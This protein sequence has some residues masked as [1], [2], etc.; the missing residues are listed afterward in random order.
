[1]PEHEVPVL[2][3]GGGGCGLSASI[4]LSNL[5]VENLVVE[6]H[7][8]TSLLPKAHYLNQRTMEAFRQ[9]GVSDA[10][11][12]VGPRSRSSA[13]CAGQPP[14]AATGRWTSASST[15]WTPSAVAPS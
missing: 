3:I 1:M 8:S 7:A 4:F 12:A 13:R 9:H 11:L 15:R 14:W 5:G 10:I 2:I 6:R